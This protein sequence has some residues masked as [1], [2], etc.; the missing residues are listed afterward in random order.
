MSER[1]L[2]IEFPNDGDD[3]ALKRQLHIETILAKQHDQILKI[4]GV[5]GIVFPSTRTPMITVLVDPA[6]H[7]QTRSSV[8]RL[9]NRLGMPKGAHV[10]DASTHSFAANGNSPS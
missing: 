6:A 8:T 2:A 1:Q 3:E 4:K 9:M 5:N 10:F 7:Y